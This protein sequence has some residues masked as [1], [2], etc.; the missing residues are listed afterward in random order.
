VLGEHKIDSNSV[1]KLTGTTWPNPKDSRNEFYAWDIKPETTSIDNF[2]VTPEMHKRLKQFQARRRQKPIDRCREIA[3]EMIQSVTGIYGRD[4]LHVAMD[5]VFHSVLNFEFDGKM[6]ERGWLDFIVVGDTR[7]GKSETALRLSEHYRAGHIIGCESATF[8]GLVGG[9]KQVG[10]EWAISWG[11]ITIN[12]R[13]LVVLDEASGLS[14]EVISKMSD[15]RSRGVAQVTAIE[16]RQTKARC[17]AIWI[18]NPRRPKFIDERRTD[19]ID[20]IDELIGNQEDIARFDFAMSV[21]S[22]DVPLEIVNQPRERPEP[23]YTSDDCHD[24]VLWAWSRKPEH[25]RWQGRAYNK[26]YE[27][28]EWL[29]K[30]YVEHP[31]LINRANV[32]EKIARMAVA[33]AARLFSTD[34]TGELVLVTEDHV[35]AAVNFINELYQYDNFGY[36]RISKRYFRNQQIAKA[37]RSEIVMWLKENPRV[38]EFLVDKKG[39]FRAQ[40]MEE[41]AFMKKDEVNMALGVLSDAKMINKDK[42]QI[43]LEPELQSILRDIERR[44]FK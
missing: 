28:A 37:R 42:S 17:R 33:F 3:Q 10:K 1:A 12:D 19:G 41:M 8:A 39:S 40:D 24:L 21:R 27:G 9:V 14:H 4:R 20:I 32:K 15:V 7:T 30:K 5:L 29:G 2:T 11:E 18:S 31:P 36:G 44:S 38:L 25:V 43:V 23:K 35:Q 16:T 22:N 34:A 13:R 6:L 26:V